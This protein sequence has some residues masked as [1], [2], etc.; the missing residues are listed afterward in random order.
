MNYQELNTKYLQVFDY[1]AKNR[2]KDAIDAL[3]FLCNHCPNRDLRTQL[4]EHADTY[5]NLLKYAFE[6]TED[7]QKEKVYNRLVKA[8]IGLADDVKEDIIRSGN[9]LSHYKLRLVP[10]S[11]SDQV[12]SDT[13]RTMEQILLSK[14][15][16]VE[17]N[18]QDIYASREYQE[19][20]RALFRVLWHSDKLKDT[21]IRL[22]ERISK[23]DAV[24]WYDK[25]ILVSALNLSLIRHFDSNKINLLFHF[26]ESGQKQ[27]WE[28]A[29]VS[30]VLSLAFYDS[31]LVYYPEIMQRLK[32]TQGMKHAEKSIEIIVQQFIKAR[33]TEKLTRKIQQEIMP[34][35]MRMK[36]RL[37]EKL[38][39]ENLLTSLD[40]EE[41]NPEWETF[42]KEAPDIYNKMEE[43]TNL[44]LEGSDVFLGA[45]ALLK[46]FDFFDEISN[47]F[48]PFYKENEN[49]A[50]AF[51]GF[52][53]ETFNVGQF[54][55]GI[56]RSNFL[57]NSDKYS[58]CLNIRHMPA[59]QK[60]TVMELFTMELKAMNEM[61]ADDELIN[62]EARSKVII[63]QYF[64][65][66]YRFYKLHPMRAEFDDVFKLPPALY[67]N[68]FFRQWIDDIGILRNIGEFFF[69]RNY[70][71]DALLIFE[72]IVENKNSH[73]LYEKIAYCFQQLSDYDKALE[74]YHMAELLD[75]NKFW[76][77]N[78][79][80]WCY[81]KKGDFEKAVDYYHQAEKLEPEDLQV[82]AFLGHVYMEMEK[83]EK[84]LQYYFKVEYLQPENQKV[85]RP[86][87]WCSF[88]LGKF[89]KALKYLE[90]SLIHQSGK[91]DY[92]NLAH[93]YWCQG[94]KQ[95]AIENYRLS[96]KAS[97][98]DTEWFSKALHDDSRYLEQHGIRPIEI[99]LMIDYIR[100]SAIS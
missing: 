52:T 84:A 28:R 3:G 39:L 99:P 4:D 100:L 91:H 77:I 7:P 27:V 31:R 57:C 8:I 11:L 66:L 17:L 88:M 98:M 5:L 25:C 54:G 70:F 76:L 45:F 1:I 67:E 64:H 23:S 22:V 53:D 41:K 33:E 49:I 20:I 35:M 80:A 15:S 58:F 14:E 56:E 2:I 43:F 10:E 24:A 30:L 48:L 90:K 18:I 65:D 42:F 89:D 94:E 81:R 83:F 40:P 46:Q 78:R 51:T 96:L 6:L 61:A 29:L 97:S 75:K 63:T 72:Q 86:I 37:E 12:V 50:A 36:S 38:D 82:Q 71:R 44:Q 79:I 95:K 9:L 34:E 19:N 13:S 60:S 16:D 74:Y 68:R 47:W 73:E 26:Y 92:M 87:S 93:V 62:A 59:F 55:E 32:A 85:H 21:V 69:S